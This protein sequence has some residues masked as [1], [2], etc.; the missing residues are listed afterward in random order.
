MLFRR[1]QE[2]S[3]GERARA[4][5]WPRS[6]WVRS[7]RFL[8][9]RLFR[10]SA[11]PYEVAAGFAC[12]AAIAFVPFVGFHLA[13]SIVFAWLIRASALSAALGSLVGN[14]WT[15]PIIWVWTYKLGRWMG[16]GGSESPSDLDFVGLFGAI[17]KALLR[18]DLAYVSEAAWPI[19]G[20]ML[21]GSLPSGILVWFAA[22][23]T[24]RPLTAVYQQRRQ[25]RL[26]RREKELEPVA[27]EMQQ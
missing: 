19:F 5:M 20:P 27:K 3:L 7:V 25:G 12:G 16:V 17:L 2:L 23:Y 10:L 8:L 22:F 18:F 14:P 1:R 11:T 6:G 15:F 9:H 4:L 24:L 21:V 26:R 13:L